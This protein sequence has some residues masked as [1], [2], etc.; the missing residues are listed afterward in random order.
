M[1][2]KFEYK[3]GVPY[4]DTSTFDQYHCDMD[5]ARALT[6]QNGALTNIADLPFRLILSGVGAVGNLLRMF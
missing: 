4:C 2:I 5:R 3:N 1:S 6:R